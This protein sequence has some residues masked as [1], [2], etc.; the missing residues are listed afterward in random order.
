MFKRIFVLLLMAV[1]FGACSNGLAQSAVD[2]AIGGTIT[3]TE[4]LVVPNAKVEV[5]NNGTNAEQV[6]MTDGG[7]YFRA[8]HLQP[9]SYSVTITAAGFDT[10]SATAVTVE[11]GLLRDLQAKLKVGSEAQ[12]VEVTSAPPPINTTSA[13]FTG[14][15]DLKVL[16]DLPINNYRWSAYALLTPGVVSDTNGYGLLSFRGQSTLLNNITID[17][18]DDNQAFYSEERGRTRAGYSTAKASIQEFQVNT[19]NYSTEYGRS[20]GGVINSITKS[21]TNQFHGE[22]YFFDRDAEWGAKNKFTTLQGTVFKPKD[23]R[24]QWGFGVGG[25]I[26]RTSCSSSWRMTSSSII[27][28]LSRWP[29]IHRRMTL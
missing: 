21:G 20:A 16:Q 1:S 4:G 18:V 27:S 13:D 11:V 2:G 15:I 29:A 24:K 28:P 12:T 25:P 6:V 3:D 23:W 19:S 8:I 7:G 17:G 14:Q 9:G 26:I 22:G 5:R 10:Y